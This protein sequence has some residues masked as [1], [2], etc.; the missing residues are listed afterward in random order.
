VLVE[1]HKNKENNRY[2]EKLNRR[3]RGSRSY[4]RETVKLLA[5]N[6]LIDIKPLKKIKLLKLTDKGKK[7]TDSIIQIRTE[8]GQL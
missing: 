4:I 6:S 7:I 2:C 3:I 5:K 1:I 8:L